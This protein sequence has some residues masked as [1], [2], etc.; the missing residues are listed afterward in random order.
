M[1]FG[2]CRVVVL[3]V[4]FSIAV[5]LYPFFLAAA[6]SEFPVPE[7]IKKN[8]D[9]WKKVYAWYSSNYVLIHDV[10]YPDVVY[11]I[12]NL[13]D[14]YPEETDLR[15]KWKKVEKIKEEYKDILTKLAGLPVPI[16]TTS[17]NEDELRVLKLWQ[18]IDDKEKYK[19]AVGRLRGQ[20]GLRDKFQKGLERSGLYLNKIQEIF[21]QYGLP[22]DLCYLPH[23]E[24]SFYYKA[25]SKMGAA[26]LWQFTR[27]TGRLFMDIN[28]SID[29]RFD[30]IISTHAA[31]KLLKKNYEELGS[32]PLAIT[33][34]NHGLAGMK[35]ATSVL[36]SEDFGEIFEKYQSRSFGFASKNFYAEFI[37]ASEIAKNY[38]E[39]FGP[40]QFEEPIEYKEFS[41][42]DYVMMDDLAKTYNLGK[43][44]LA[45]YN[46][47]FRSSLLNSSRRIPKGYKIRLP[48]VDGLD[49]QTLYVGIAG[50]KKHDAQVRDQYYQVQSGDNLSLIA[51]RYK[52]PL[53]TLIALNNLHNAHYIRA[54]QLLELPTDQGTQQYAQMQPAL[55]TSDNEQKADFVTEDETTSEVFVSDDTVSKKSVELISDS[56]K[57]VESHVEPFVG[58]AVVPEDMDFYGPELPTVTT[59]SATSGSDTLTSTDGYFIVPFEPPKS[60]WVIVQP[61]ETLGHYA[62]WLNTSAQRLRNL[63]NIAFGTDI[64]VGKKLLLPFTSVSP[65][66][67]HQERVEFHKSIQEDFFA[68][69]RVEKLV[70]YIIKKGDNVWDLSQR[71]FQIPYWLLV[72]YNAGKDLLRL[73]PGES[74]DVPVIIP[75]DEESYTSQAD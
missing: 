15:T 69:Y 66:L 14:F 43:E 72:R 28:Y 10:D 46:P 53:E 5:C 25:Y 21:E 38:L 16:D 3:I 51:R 60:N 41:L 49:P 71:R 64:Q 23:V 29:E 59:A 31:A 34:Y 54:G 6:S 57:N 26:G 50:D 65:E 19:S 56:V 73:F 9:F 35:R 70:P 4:I 63:N 27:S 68:H 1:G 55:Q 32:W 12:V 8:V 47:A 17:L 67:F 22:P 18:K 33:A 52:V 2:M 39:Y 7:Q 40:I 36:N 61:E 42:P 13:N 62:E 30:P 24:S 11:Q 45:E 20:M 37:A 75:R 48:N 58:H 74:I 44:I